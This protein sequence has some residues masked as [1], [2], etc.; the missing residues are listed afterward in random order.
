[1]K[2]TILISVLIILST[3]AYSSYLD[4]WSNNDLCGWMESASVP[5]YIQ[6]E[7]EKREILC[8]SGIEVSSMPSEVN[9]QSENG[10]VF[11]SPDPSLI[12][13]LESTYGQGVE[14]TMGSSY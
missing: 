1:M 12:S 7:V 11:A 10:T 14:Q 13:E 2:K 6:N 4:T 3:R 5:E 8:F 9:L